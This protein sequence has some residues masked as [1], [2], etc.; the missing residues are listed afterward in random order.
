MLEN[1]FRIAAEIRVFA[2]CK[3]L[4]VLMCN[5]SFLIRPIYLF[6]INCKDSDK[7]E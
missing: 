7:L 2:L 4:V 6:I 1:V 3:T 5:S